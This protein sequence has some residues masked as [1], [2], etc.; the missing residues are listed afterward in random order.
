M[1]LSSFKSINIPSFLNPDD[2]DEVVEEAEEVV[3][4]VV[5]E[6]EE[7]VEEVVDEVKEVVEEVVVEVVDCDTLLAA[8]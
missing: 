5:D 6:V 3:E 8:F 7:E 2:L 4:E 1:P